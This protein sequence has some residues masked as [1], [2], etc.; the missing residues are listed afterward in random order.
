MSN[1][2]IQVP[3]TP[4]ASYSYPFK[5]SIPRGY[6]YHYPLVKL[7]GDRETGLVDTI[8]SI[9]NEAELKEYPYNF[10]K[11]VLANFLA[12]SKEKR[13]SDTDQSSPILLNMDD[14]ELQKLFTTDTFFIIDYDH[15]IKRFKLTGNKLTSK[16]KNSGT[17]RKKDRSRLADSSSKR[18]SY[19]S[20]NAYISNKF[21]DIIGDH[22][23]P[24]Y[25]SYLVITEMIRIIINYL[26]TLRGRQGFRG[27]RQLQ[28]QYYT[29]INIPDNAIDIN[30]HKINEHEIPFREVWHYTIL[31]YVK[32]QNMLYDEK[33]SRKKSKKKLSWETLSPDRTNIGPF[34]VLLYYILELNKQL[35][36][37]SIYRISINRALLDD[38]NK[39]LSLIA[40]KMIELY[41]LYEPGMQLQMHL[42]YTDDDINR[43]L[44]KIEIP[45]LTSPQSARLAS[46]SIR[47]NYS[48]RRAKSI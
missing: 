6:E 22:L 32:Y 10:L 38:I 39:D 29:D 48:R 12:N 40:H 46:N 44:F 4:V 25:D 9:K 43:P 13:G 35:E 27:S 19:K 1:K 42:Q 5:K 16:T 41:E 17:Y 23:L 3:F 14:T 45:P 26:R 28:P 11:T 18:K 37:L 20:Y 30:G 15:L 8:Y 36:F 21:R 2:L 33:L 24:S 47:P 31:G 7:L 34:D